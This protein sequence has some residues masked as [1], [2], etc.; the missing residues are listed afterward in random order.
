MKLDLVVRNGNVVTATEEAFCD[1]GI[2]G[3]RIAA[4]A[5][6]LDSAEREIDAD[7][8]Y[9]FPGG[10]DSNCHIEQ[11]SS[12]GL[13]CADDFYSG[14]V[15]AAFGGTTTIV[16]FAAQHRGDSLKKIVSGYHARAKAKAVVDYAFH[17][18]LSDPTE[19]VL[20]DELPELIR[21]GYS[22]VKVSTSCDGLRLDDYQILEV[23][24]L[25][26][27]EGALTMVQ[28]ENHDMIRW[29]TE[30]LLYRGARVSGYHAVA[31]PR[32]AESEAVSRT[33]ALAELVDAPILILHV[34]SDEALAAIRRAQGRGL[35]VYAETCPQYLFFTADDLEGEGK[36]G[37]RFCCSP[38]P[39]DQ[40][41]QEA[42]WRG[43]SD[44]TFQILSSDHA[45]YRFDETGKL[46]SIAEARFDEIADGV[47]GL[48]V[49]MPLLFS[50][51]V[52]GGRIDIH[53]FVELTSTRAAKLYGM[54]PQKGSI[55]IGADADLVIWDAEREVVIESGKLHDN[56]GYTPYE[57]RRLTG[58]PITVLSRGRVVVADGA[59]Q[60]ERGSGA[61]VAREK[62]EAADPTGRPV[63]EWQLARR[64]GTSE[65]W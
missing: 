29:L 57:G 28:A 33:I 26:R 5:K 4:I 52:R 60:A 25:A 30:R 18:F 44:G 10:I 64:L 16:S 36:E 38:P 27:R 65:A 58:W 47:P 63:P 21:N 61:F 62:P 14:T 54:F 24:S 7:G 6:K 56:S 50:E 31:H 3:G 15:S 20:R 32:L 42:M 22:S 19:T 59:L 51:G 8:H 13:S 23:L 45:S 53:R 34:S 40:K 49:R 39:R 46:A 48:E 55:S 37:A 35:K 43:L 11:P 1:I 12:S 17:L 2:A 41:A 9:I